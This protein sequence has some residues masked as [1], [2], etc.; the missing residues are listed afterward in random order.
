[1]LDVILLSLAVAAP[2]QQRTDTTFN[3]DARGR[4]DLENQNGDI[5]IRSWDRNAVRIAADHARRTEI[6]IDNVGS[7]VR[8]EAEHDGRS[9]RGGNRVAYEVWVPAGFDINVDAQNG[10]VSLQDIGGEVEV[11]TVNGSIVLRGGT[12]R[13]DLES[14]SGE[15]IVEGARGAIEAVTVNRGVR[16]TGSSGDINA[17]SINGSIQL[18]DIESANVQAE[19]LN[20]SIQYRGAIRDGGRYSFASHNGGITMT[21][22]EGTNASFSVT[23]H[24]GSI[25]TDFPVQVRDLNSRRSLSFRLGDG[26]ARI[27]LESFGGSVHLRRPGGR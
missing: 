25:E 1:M 4:L 13:V 17:E 12:G 9:G 27:E 22:P 3:V 19:S 10:D 7:V 6:Q 26:G 2:Q 24:N 18:S 8:V 14:V 11:E 23:T 15:V 21:I 5:I 20:G 16:I